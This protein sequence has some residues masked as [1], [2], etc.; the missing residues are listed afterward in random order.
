MPRLEKTMGVKFKSPPKYEVRS[1][2]EVRQFLEKRFTEDLPDAEVRG[3]ERAYKRFGLLPGTLDL[4][5]FMLKLL[6]EQIAGYYDPA[7]KVLY[8]VQGA[9]DDMLSITVSHELVHALQD[10]YFNLD[11]LQKVKR[12]NDRQVAA[13]AVIEGQAMLEQIASMIG[14][15]T[16]IANLPGGWDRVREMIRDGQNSMPIFANAPMLI[17]ETLL[18]PYLSGAEFMKNWK[19][20]S[21]GKLPFDDMPVST[22]QVMHE[23]RFFLD[24]DEPT[25]ITLPAPAGGGDAYENDFGEFETRL[26]LFQHLKDRDAAFRGAAGWDGDRY[27]SFTTGRGD[28]VAWL[29]VWDTSVDAAEFY[30]LVDTALLKRFEDIKPVQGSGDRRVYSTR[31]RT[32]AVTAATLHGRPCVLY[33]DVPAGSNVNVIDLAKVVLEE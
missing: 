25:A 21:G 17:Q 32:I 16:A 9:S 30:D 24:R 11:S 10:Q 8:I 12:R 28:G 20:K 6:T 18:F 4:R 33:V 26:F 7:T 23:D 5:S 14:S 3:T 13:Q 22:E 1:K 29:S 15:G 27:V 2:D 31:G 19:E